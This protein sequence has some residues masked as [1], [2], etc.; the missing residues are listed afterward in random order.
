MPYA[1]GIHG[2]DIGCDFVHAHSANRKWG[3]LLF[4]L[5]VEIKCQELGPKVSLMHPHPMSK[6]DRGRGGGGWKG[7][8]KWVG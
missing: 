8:G 3:L 2:C 7:L 6:K 5:F 1:V 4:M